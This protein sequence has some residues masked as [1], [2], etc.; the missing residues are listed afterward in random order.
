MAPEQREGRNK[1]RQ[2]LKEKCLHHSTL[3]KFLWEGF[4]QERWE[5]ISPDGMLKMLH[6][7]FL[8][9]LLDNEDLFVPYFSD[10]VTIRKLFGE[11]VIN[12]V[13]RALKLACQLPISRYAP[14]STVDVPLEARVARDSYQDIS[15]E[16]FSVL[17]NLDSSYLPLLQKENDNCMIQL[18]EH[19]KK[20]WKLSSFQIKDL[21]SKY[22]QKGQ[23]V[24]NSL[25]KERKTEYSTWFDS[26]LIIPTYP[27]IMQELSS[28]SMEREIIGEGSTYHLA[29]EKEIWQKFAS[30]YAREGL[31]LEEGPGMTEQLV[32]P[33]PLKG[34]IILPQFSNL[35]P[36]KEDNREL[37]PLLAALQAGFSRNNLYGEGKEL[38]TFLEQFPNPRYAY[39]LW[40]QL[41]YVQSKHL[42]KDNFAGLQTRLEQLLSMKNIQ[43]GNSNPELP[44][45]EKFLSFLERRLLWE[46]NEKAP[47]GIKVE[48]EK[49]MNSLPDL[50]EMDN[51]Q[52]RE[53]VKRLYIQINHCWKIPRLE[54]KKQG[55][56]TGGW[57]NLADRTGASYQTQDIFFY[58]EPSGG[59]ARLIVKDASGFP[60]TRVEDF[61]RESASSLAQ[62]ISYFERIKP[63]RVIIKRRQYEGELDESAYAEMLLELKSGYQPDTAVFQQRLVREREN[64]FLFSINQSRK[65][66][67]WIGD[68]RTVDY[69]LATTILLSEAA[70]ILEDRF[71]I[72]GHTSRGPNEVFLNVFKDF[73]QKVTA[74]TNAKLGLLA[75]LYQ[76]RAGTFYKHV[77]TFF[78]EVSARRKIHFD[79]ITEIGGDE[80]YSEDLAIEDLMAGVRKEQ[81]HGIEVYSF[82]LNPTVTIQQLDRIYGA[83]H[84]LKIDNPK[85]LPTLALEI[86]Q[87]VT[88]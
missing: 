3:L 15:T 68:K 60:N 13:N 37:Y 41:N 51:N 65:L 87:R 11:K 62:V 14:K 53:T 10:Q 80:N 56:D 38:P 83:G 74:E 36:K 86:Y 88:L 35:F 81:V 70:R 71:A 30:L 49:I 50:T 21:L 54:G 18:V 76:S 26:L 82:C 12:E 45:I 23:Q 40:A 6:D 59:R 61:K 27:Q 58:D 16:I 32:L 33:L 7:I 31:R 79:V 19:A 57:F 17:A 72:V 75:P 25:S 78:S 22:I 52:I 66:G 42:I 55:T 69:V 46:I 67:V 2:F 29:E 44:P 73:S 5:D 64:A 4:S 9:K 85:H 8:T 77:P 39:R 84:Y 20:K 34:R 24:F 1:I 48:A 47:T 63:E 43:F 28:H